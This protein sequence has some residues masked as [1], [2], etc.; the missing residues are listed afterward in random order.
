MRRIRVTGR[1][2][3]RLYQKMR[4]PPRRRTT[5]WTFSGAS[6]GGQKRMHVKRMTRLGVGT[7]ACP[8]AG[9]VVAGPAF[10]DSPEVVAG[11]PTATALSL[12][13][14][15]NALTLG[16]STAAAASTA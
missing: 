15:G 9:W 4:Q 7:A 2:T 8:L 6:P 16:S 13:V 11:S 3:V 14:V 5:R 10:A 12:S 1:R